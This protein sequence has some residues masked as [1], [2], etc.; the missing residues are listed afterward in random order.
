M[1]RRRTGVI[2]RR[3]TRRRAFVR[4]R[5]RSVPLMK[6]PVGRDVRCLDH[7]M[8]GGGRLMPRGPDRCGVIRLRNVRVGRYFGDDLS[9]CDAADDT[10]SAHPR[11]DSDDDAPDHSPRSPPPGV[12]VRGRGPS[13]QGG[14]GCSRQEGATV[15]RDCRGS[16]SWPWMTEP[17][18]RVQIGGVTGHRETRDWERG[19][20]ERDRQSGRVAATNS[21][22]HWSVSA[23]ESAHRQPPQIDSSK[24]F[25]RTGSGTKTARRV[26]ATGC[27]EF[28]IARSTSGVPVTRVKRGE[29]RVSLPTGPSGDDDRRSRRPRTPIERACSPVRE[30]P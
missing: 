6:E 24:E 13:V 19:T 8:G 27:F 25:V 15:R 17:L 26:P 12:S 14:F 18:G 23:L 20:G 11:T 9:R 10:V 28:Q 16:R 21:R 29:S 7:A 22:G 5:Y 4:R 1:L 30:R 2:L 3:R